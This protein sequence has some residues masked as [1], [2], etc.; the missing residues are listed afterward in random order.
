MLIV[1]FINHQ[2]KV[3]SVVSNF[4]KKLVPRSEDITEEMAGESKTIIYKSRRVYITTL[5]TDVDLFTPVKTSATI[6]SIN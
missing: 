5:R 6:S 2:K 4:S 3:A 1:H